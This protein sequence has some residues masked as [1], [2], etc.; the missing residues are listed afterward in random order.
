MGIIIICYLLNKYE[1]KMDRQKTSVFSDYDPM[2]N[3]S[4]NSKQL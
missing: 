4:L 2:E 1:N 3:S